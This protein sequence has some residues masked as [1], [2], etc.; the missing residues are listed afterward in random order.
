MSRSLTLTW[1][2]PMPLAQAARSMSGLEFLRAVRDGTLTLFAFP[3][4]F[5][6]NGQGQAIQ[7]PRVRICRHGRGSK[8]H[9]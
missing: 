5:P 1:Q 9:R 2:D 3:T 4:G 6:V 8:R 7:L